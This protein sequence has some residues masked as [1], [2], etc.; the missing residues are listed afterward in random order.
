VA[1]IE[2]PR[3]RAPMIAKAIG[4]AL[5]TFIGVFLAIADTHLPLVAPLLFIALGA[6]M[7]ARNALWLAKGTPSV[8]ATDE[9][10]WFG[11]GRVIAW[12][13]VS[14]IY[15]SN[16]EVRMRGVRAKPSA[17]AFDFRDLRARLRLPLSALLASPFSV[18][19]IDVSTADMN[20]N[21]MVVVAKLEAMR[22]L[23]K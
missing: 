8:R 22:A 16:L 1:T 13:D 18:G 6:P 2:L 12:R 7:L 10:V 4:A 23:S 20:E 15:E 9:G 21:A 11:G 3:A 14:A 17:I 19:D 5:L